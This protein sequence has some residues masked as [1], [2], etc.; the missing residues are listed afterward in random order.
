MEATIKTNKCASTLTIKED[1]DMILEEN[2]T[3]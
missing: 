3:Y 2:N 1:F